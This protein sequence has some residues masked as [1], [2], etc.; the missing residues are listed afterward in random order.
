MKTEMILKSFHT[1]GIPRCCWLHALGYGHVRSLDQQ[2]FKRLRLGG[3]EPGG[4][5]QQI[6]PA[7]ERSAEQT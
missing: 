6:R 7:S 4:G 1:D 2:A 3:G 5:P